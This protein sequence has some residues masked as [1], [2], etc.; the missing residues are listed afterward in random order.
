MEE[1]FAWSNRLTGEAAGVDDYVWPQ[2]ASSLLERL[3]HCQQTLIPL[4]GLQG[5]GKTSAAQAIARAL[6]E[7]LKKQDHGEEDE[8]EEDEDERAHV[9]LVRISA[10]GQL[11]DSIWDQNSEEIKEKCYLPVLQ[12][13][14]RERTEKNPIFRMKVARILG[15][16]ISSS[17]RMSGEERKRINDGLKEFGLEAAEAAFLKK[18]ER[19][20]MRDEAIFSY[21]AMAHT[22]II[23]LPDYSRKDH[24]LMNKDI[25]DVQELWKRGILESESLMGGNLNLVYT[26]QKET[27]GG[28]YFTGKGGIV[29]IR[30]FT[31]GELVSAYSKIWEKEF[32]SAGIDLRTWPFE[33]KA[34]LYLARC[35]RGIFRRFMKYIGMCLEKSMSS[36]DLSEQPVDLKRAQSAVD[37][38]EIQKDWET[39]LSRIFKKE[40]TQRLAMKIVVA[41]MKTG[42]VSQGNLAKGL[43]VSEVAVSRILGP[44]E[45]NGFIVREWRGQEKIVRANI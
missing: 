17:I 24:R 18:G 14:L 6:E 15:V 5:V 4:I 2:A 3:K 1:I 36:A 7:Y 40:D 42:E 22:V 21:V 44:L 33:E 9:V 38:E 27:L 29:E 25:N 11:L 16:S 12:E 31:A 35:A 32:A 43:Q 23:D 19:K 20:I 8:N 30:P 26:L 28:H 13:E 10:A 39:E 37:W 34:L 41:L 45:E